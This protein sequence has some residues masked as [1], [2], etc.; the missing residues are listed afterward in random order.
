MQYGICNL[1][2]IPVRK[3]A[4]HTSEMVSQLLFG[5]TFDIF[6]QEDCWVEVQLHSDNYTGWIHEQQYLSLDKP[7]LDALNA[8]SKVLVTD[9][10]SSVTEESSGNSLPLL[11]GSTLPLPLENRFNI[12]NEAYT[13]KGDHFTPISQ[14]EDIVK[15]AALYLGSPYLWGGRTHFGIDCSGFTQIVYKLAGVALPRDASQQAQEGETLSFLSEAEVGDLLFF[16][17]AEGNIVHVGILYSANKIIHALGNVR[18]DTI[19]HQGIYN[20][21]LQKYTHQLRLIKRSCKF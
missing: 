13:F 9:L 6:N 21:S 2:I 20:E 3:S 19:D 4:G 1:S 14:K 12:G 15:Y 11:P 7:A 16:D 17:N 5:E 18:I 8:N 10:L